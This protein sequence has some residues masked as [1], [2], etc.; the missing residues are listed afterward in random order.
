V[1]EFPEIPR[2]NGISGKKDNLE[3]FLAENL[4]SI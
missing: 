4:S 1:L 2:V 3:K